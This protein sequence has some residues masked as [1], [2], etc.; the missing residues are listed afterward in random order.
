MSSEFE[1]DGTTQTPGENGGTADGQQQS[2]PAPQAPAGRSFTDA[3]M[4]AARRSWEA[5]ARKSEQRLRQEL[6]QQFIPREQPKP[7][8]PWSKFDPQVAAAMRE[9]M[10]HEFQQRL[11]P[12]KAQQDDIAF[13]ND[14]A[15]IR[16]RYPD[17]SANRLAVL[18]FGVQHGI[19]DIE[20]AYRSWKYDQLATV[21][22]K[23][24]GQD[25]V[26]AYL[27]KKTAQAVQTPA[28]EGRGGAAPSSQQKFKTREEMDE[29][30]LEMI[31]A[32]DNT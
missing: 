29:A 26:A 12:F 24:I 30:V 10:E 18:E 32:A 8:D 16:T 2:T 15:E 9:V 7:N 21:D 5:D 3:D 20:Q 14:E 22:P 13:R 19:A 11:T 31:H 6:S 27:K 25:A 4:A 23:R 17:Y 1:T 28:S